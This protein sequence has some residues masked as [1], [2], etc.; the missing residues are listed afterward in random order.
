MKKQTIF[1]TIVGSTSFIIFTYILKSFSP[2]SQIS[3][4]LLSFSVTPIFFIF[5]FLTM[6]SLV[7]VL[8]KRKLHG[9]LIASGTVAYLILRM[10]GFTQIFYAI[11][12]LALIL[13]LELA[14]G[15]FR[16]KKDQSTL[17]SR[18]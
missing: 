16:N 17:S 15:N 9:L 1:L 5:L 12:L 8:L 11:F 2:N 4:G 6:F 10:Y 13:T 3:L 14:F 18:T 7:T